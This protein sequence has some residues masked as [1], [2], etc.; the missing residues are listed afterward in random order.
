MQPSIAGPCFPPA[1]PPTAAADCT[2]HDRVSKRLHCDIVPGLQEQYG[3]PNI[4]M[5][6]AIRNRSRGG[7]PAEPLWHQPQGWLHPVGWHDELSVFASPCSNCPH[8]SHLPHA[9]LHPWHGALQALDHSVCMG[10]LPLLLTPYRMLPT[11]TSWRRG[12]SGPCC[13]GSPPTSPCTGTR[14]H[15][16]AVA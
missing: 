8:G 7:A 16:S 6:D 2:L 1:P 4:R 11:Q 3:Y 9:S 15:P 14:W 5:A 12:M 13:T 10:N